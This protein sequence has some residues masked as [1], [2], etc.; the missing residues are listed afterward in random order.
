VS[1][2][3]G[4]LSLLTGIAYTGLG[5]ITAYELARH[6]RSRGHSHFGLG[7]LLMA[8]TCG[9]HHLVHAVHFLL[10]GRTASAPL[11]AALALGLPPGVAFTGLRFE[12]L[13]GGRG[14]RF[15]PGTPAPVAVLPCAIAV[16]AGA[17][18]F[19]AVQASPGPSGAWGWAGLAANVFLCAAYLITGKIVF[20]TQV[21][22]RPGLGGWSI[23]GLAMA[24]VFFT[25][26]ISHA[27][28]GLTA[29]AE[30][31]TLTVDL[32]GIPAAAY[33]LWAVH[34]LHR[35]SLNDWNRR[36]LVG[37]AGRQGRP[38]PWAAELT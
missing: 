12:A 22:R 2:A 36:P 18:G 17:I 14:D 8:T 38:A 6:T 32:P 27:V 21:A 25:C 20:S 11:V 29:G 34:R 28:A 30:L 10:E 5:A 33:F 1:L 13:L 26:G 7:F 35:S 4:I 15:A 31:H 23:S 16:A 19:A 37:R 24:G 3:A 9:P